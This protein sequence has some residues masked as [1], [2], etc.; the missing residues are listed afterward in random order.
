MMGDV[1]FLYSNGN[2][3]RVIFDVVSLKIKHD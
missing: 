2:T 3:D 1:R